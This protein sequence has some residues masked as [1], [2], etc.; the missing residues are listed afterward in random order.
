[1]RGITPSERREKLSANDANSREIRN[2]LHGFHEFA[3][4]SEIRVKTMLYPSA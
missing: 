1:M 3:L 4:I 2:I